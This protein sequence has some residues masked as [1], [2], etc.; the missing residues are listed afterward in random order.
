MN[1][2][3]LYLYL[4]LITIFPNTLTAFNMLPNPSFENT[5][6]NLPT[7]WRAASGWKG[8]SNYMVTTEDV[9]AGKYAAVIERKVADKG[10]GAFFSA[11]VP[12]KSGNLYNISGS[13]K[14]V[15][16][17]GR[18]DVAIS[19]YNA[20]NKSIKYQLLAF[21]KK[22]VPWKKKSFTIRAPKGAVKARFLLVLSG[23]GKAYFDDFYFNSKTADSSKKVKEKITFSASDNLVSNGTFKALNAQKMPKMWYPATTWKG[24]SFYS[25]D[26]SNGR[27]TAKIKRTDFEGAGAWKS[28][29]I[30]IK[31]RKL[32]CFRAEI[33]TYQVTGRADFAINFFNSKGKVINYRL[34]SKYSGTHD[35]TS[36]QKVL[37]APP[38]A[39]KANIL[40]VQSGT[41]EAWFSN[42]YLGTNIPGSSSKS[43][44]NLILNSSFEEADFNSDFIDCFSV[45]EGTA[46]RSQKAKHGF[47]ALRLAPQT[48][49]LYGG[50]APTLALKSGQKLYYNL[51]VHGTGN[52]ILELKYYNKNSKICGKKQIAFQGVD[53]TYKQRTGQISIPPKVRFASLSLIN[54]SSNKDVIIDSLYLG[55]KP[56]SKTL[57]PTPV[58][59]FPAFKNLSGMKPMLPSKVKNYKGLPTWFL[60]GKPVVS[61]IFTLIA[62]TLR[63][64]KWRKYNAKILQKGQFPILMLCVYITPEMAGEKYTITSALQKADALIRFAQS[65]LP[66]VKFIFWVYQE[67]AFKFAT[68]YPD[69][70]L[71]V[72]DK[73]FPW[74]STVPPYS[75]GSE[76]WGKMC[77]QSLKHFIQELRT[78][79]YGDKVVGVMPGMG[80]YGENN[81]GHAGLRGGYSAH[82]FSFAMQNYF[83][84]WLFKE[85][86]FNVKYFEKAWKRKHFNFTNAEV[87]SS[88][89][90]LPKL[91]GAFFDPKLQR[92]IIDYT[93]CESAVIIHR[94][95]EQVRAAKAAT[96]GNIFTILQLAYF[97][98][99]FFHRELDAALK[100]KHLDALG[101]APPYVNRG[102]GDDII[103]HGPAASVRQANKVWFF[104]ADVRTHLGGELE[105]R[106]GRTKNVAESLS[107]L[108]RDLG[109][110]MTTGTIP[111]YMTFGYW[112]DHPKIWELV[113]KFEPLMQLSGY[114][115]RR[116]ATEIAVVSDSLSL[117]IGHEYSYTRRVMPPHQSTLEYNRMF[118]WHHLGA[119]YDFYLLDDLLAV[120]NLKQYKLIIMANTFALNKKQR[121]LIKKRLQRDNRTIIYM[122]APGLMTQ[123]QTSINY[124]I[125]NSSITGFDFKLDEKKHDL[126][127]KLPSNNLAGYFRNKIYGGFT[128]PAKPKNVRREKFSPRLS[129]KSKAGVEILGRYADDGAIGFARK[130]FPTHTAIFW[131]STALDQ[132][133]LQKLAKAAGVH[134]YTNGKSVVYANSNFM[135]IHVPHAGKRVIKLPRR[136]EQ[137]VDLFSGQVIGRNTD[138]VNVD[139]KKNDTR[140]LYFGKAAALKKAQLE[141]QSKLQARKK[142]NNEL[143]P[144]HVYKSVKLPILGKKASL[145]GVYNPDKT[146]F[147]KHWLIAGPFPNYAKSPA[148]NIDYL[149]STGG[150]AKTLP[151]AGI[152]YD[153]EFDARGKDREAERSL[154]FG[155]KA[156]KKGLK[157]SWL[158]FAFSKGIVAPLYRQIDY[159]MTFDKICYYAAC[160]VKVNADVKLVLCIG[161][162]DGN[163]VYV[164]GKLVTKKNVPQG[165]GIR[166]DSE[167]AV[168]KLKKGVNLILIKILQG[169]GGL[170]HAL[171]FKRLED[172]KIFTDYKIKLKKD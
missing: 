29:K 2:K 23:T 123:K 8:K 6:K 94:L 169:G 97:T 148:F 33:K 117:S 53:N 46:K 151:A 73:S 133:V 129:V 61:S 17:T 104:Q 3:Y 108:L 10:A 70:I 161:S 103:D 50:K 157:I 127:I 158:P 24:K 21:Q 100:S 18:S 54:S 145:A 37:I 135:S 146:G 52:V 9:V 119:P 170:G 115:P 159:F 71:K 118:E 124:D 99:S 30:N 109:H 11:F 140:L 41:G 20:A 110:Y 32:Y 92:N 138:K 149:E 136:A 91:K 48:K 59:V 141:I 93:R 78:R 114:F 168:V 72:E 143:A 16:V 42:I 90:R 112:Y 5:K 101:P 39:V 14:S 80:E 89:Q 31:A 155:G 77:A 34:I 162:D 49:L 165:R 106:Y 153:A 95:L 84:K 65:V 163:K 121:E 88:I 102:P 154:W 60:D 44:K 142:R 12:V 38:D 160:Y 125:A 74:A 25:S 69:Q 172:G 144:Q 82:D 131:G 15:A 171:R 13:F 63:N 51:A 43:P 166:P 19:F 66:D 45:A 150:E 107:I 111:Y 57:L 86:K 87:P 139:F 76:I 28:K 55:E 113:S 105:W 137:I 62:N 147:I 152:R 128:T 64:T 81:F 56:F 126:S 167:R 67:P 85:Y 156:Q 120:K 58:P 83:R 132:V 27:T 130:K 164:N 47:H 75:Y 96:N 1:I 79:P 36:K 40:L 4:A 98:E 134:I 22:T 7:Y 68:D 122:Y 26:A 35:W 116:P